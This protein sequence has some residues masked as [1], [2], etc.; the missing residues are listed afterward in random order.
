MPKPVA[1]RGPRLDYR[2]GLDGLRAI[3][4]AGVFLYHARP[5]ADGSPYLPGGFLGVDLFFVLSG[6]LLTSLLLVEWEA[7]NR[8]D[9]RRFWLR[10]ARRL[11]PALVVV[12]LAALILASIFAR[13]DLGRTRGDAVSSLLYYTNWHLIVANH[14]YFTLMG[15]PSLLQ[16]LWSLAVEE[17]F[18]FVWP[19]LVLLL[20]RRALIRT[21]AVLVAAA[22]LARV[23]LRLGGAGEVATYVLP[24]ARMD[25]LLLGALVA[26][27]VRELGSVAPLARHA[28]RVLAASGTVAAA[29]LAFAP[30]RMSWSS[31]A[32]Q[33][34][35]LTAIAV[36]FAA[37][38]VTAV[39]AP[40]SSRW[41]QVLR[42]PSL[43]T[44]GKYSYAL[45]IFHPLVLAVLQANGWGA[46]RFAGFGAGVQIGVHLVFAAFATLVSLGAA[47]L[48]WNLMEKHF[49]RLKHRFATR[50][51]AAAPELAPVPGAA[52]PAL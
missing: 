7:G 45:Y 50:P 19:P 4:V 44:F 5:H 27:A 22:L 29:T 48:S 6:Y 49:L 2:P 46:S 1:R 47:W 35:G 9:L 12:V 34:V 16:H 23:A 41:G 11:L 15:R 30:A 37:L 31:P 18:Y 21:S 10:R 13:T 26:L 38:L 3:A 33:T 42:A 25:A 17:Q 32:V 28:P 14:S 36:F 39:A 40:E 24:F 51:K 52:A 8:I 43:R 20:S